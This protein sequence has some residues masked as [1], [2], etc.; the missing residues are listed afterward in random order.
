MRYERKG[1]LEPTK[2]ERRKSR[3]CIDGL[4]LSIDTP[5]SSFFSLVGFEHTLLVYNWFY[6]SN[7]FLLLIFWLLLE[8]SECGQQTKTEQCSMLNAIRLK[9]RLW[10]F[11][12]NFWILSPGID[13]TWLTFEAPWCDISRLSWKRTKRLLFI[14]NLTDRNWTSLQSDHRLQSNN[15]FSSQHSEI[16]W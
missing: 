15:K 10:N 5:P 7:S 9:M 4:V 1:I 2:S 12:P 16:S 14:F 8:H 13:N 11:L 6:L 3:S